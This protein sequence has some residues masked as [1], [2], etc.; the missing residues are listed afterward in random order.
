MVRGYANV[1]G[2]LGM[3]TIRERRGMWRIG[4]PRCK[5]EGRRG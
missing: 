3:T 4:K 1:E 5:L 2:L